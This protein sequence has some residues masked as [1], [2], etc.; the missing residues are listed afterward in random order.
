MSAT[1]ISCLLLT[2]YYHSCIFL[3]IFCFL[4]AA[5][6][7][8]CKLG[9]IHL[10]SYRSQRLLS[11]SLSC[12]SDGTCNMFFPSSVRLPPLSMPCY[13]CPERLLG[14]LLRTEHRV[15]PQPASKEEG[16][17]RHTGSPGRVVPAS[18]PFNLISIPVSSAMS[19]LR[20]LWA[21]PPVQWA[22]LT[23]TT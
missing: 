8:M 14:L 11:L 19:C 21:S 1:E 2:Q 23:K 4:L 17:P 9:V 3:F 5:N 7:C 6:S 18:Q 15:R 12:F 20:F 16:T 13:E 10:P 22:F